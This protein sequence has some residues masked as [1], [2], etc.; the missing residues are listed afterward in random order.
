MAGADGTAVVSWS[1]WYAARSDRGHIRSNNEDSVY[2]GPRLLA[3]ADG[4]G[5]HAAGEVASKI[6]IAALE[7]LDED[8][9]PG[10][11]LAALRQATEDGSAHIR[12][13]V[14]DDPSLE[15]MG[16]TLT[17]LLFAGN[18]LAVCHIGDSRCYLLRDG[19]LAQITHDDTF[20][21]TLVDEGRLTE[22]EAHTH[23]QRS[24]ILRA[25]NGS[26]IEP[27]LSVRETRVGDRYLLCSDGLSDVVTRETMLEALQAE[28]PQQAADRLI[29]LALRGGGPDNSTCIV[30]EVINES[31]SDQ[32]VVD[33]AASDR[34]AGRSLGPSSAAGRAAMTGPQPEAP[35][36]EPVP[37]D[38][39][40]ER[41]IMRPLLVLTLILLVLAGGVFALWTVSRNQWYVGADGD[42]VAIFRGMDLSVA[43]LALSDVQSRSDVQIVD[44]RPFYR[45]AVLDGITAKSRLD[46]QRIVEGLRQQRLEP[47]PAPS[48]TTSSPSASTSTSQTATTTTGPT[49]GPSTTLPT[50]PG[51]STG[52][53]PATPTVGG[54][55]AGSTTAPTNPLPTT[56]AGPTVA[57]TLPLPGVDCRET[58]N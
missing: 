21:Q 56:S 22:E 18:R 31:A 48:P 17:A 40:A 35:A 26:E 25:L 8:A 49:T 14:N 46:A 52:S 16:T 4:M 5:G 58:G 50:I 7:P 34:P 54:T 30:A 23:P 12:E 55:T 36:A 38:P 13:L 33:G 51:Q 53:T 47:C 19:E 1:L 39:P 37:A 44:L 29:E 28:Q 20:V 2:A 6:A 42:R 11:L 41:H 43:G 32:P 24:L 27:D 3:V 9:A 45:D 10:D 15:G 57:T